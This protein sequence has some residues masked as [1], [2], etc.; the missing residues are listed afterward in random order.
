MPAVT[1]TVTL[2]DSVTAADVR[3]FAS[4]LRKREGVEKVKVNWGEN[5]DEDE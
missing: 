5:E 1:L 4:G 3:N 2:D